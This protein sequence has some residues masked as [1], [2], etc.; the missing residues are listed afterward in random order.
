VRRKI[1][2]KFG[3]K[4]VKQ[5]RHAKEEKRSKDTRVNGTAE[6]PLAYEWLISKDTAAR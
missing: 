3:M 4:G 2:A 1:R 5:R 6:E